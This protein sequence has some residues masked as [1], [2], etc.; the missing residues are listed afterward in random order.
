M[1]IITKKKNY[2][3]CAFFLTSFFSF[4]Q[5]STVD[6]WESIILNTDTFTYQTNDAAITDNNWITSSYDD[7]SW[8]Q[9]I[10]GIGYG[11]D[12]DNTVISGITSVFLRKEFTIKDTSQIASMILNIDYDD[13]FVAYLNG[14]EIAR[15]EGLNDL[16]PSYNTLSSS[17]H[18]AEIPDGGSPDNNTIST[19]ILNNYLHNGSN[20]LAVQVHNVSTTSSDFSSNVW[21]SVGLNTKEELYRSIPSWFTP[22]IS[23]FSSNLP[24]VV[25]ET[26]GATIIE[27]TKINAHMGIIYNDNGDTNYSDGEYNHYDGTIGIEIRGNSTADF[28]KKPYNIETR[29]SVGDNLNVKLLGMHKENDWVLRA[30]YIDH[31]FA[32]NSLADHLARETGFWAA[33]TRHVEVILDGEYQGI[34]V[35]ME[36]IKRDDHRVD[37]AE[38]DS[39]DIS[40][41]DVT[42]GYIWEVTGFGYNFGERRK[43]KYPKYD[44]IM[45][46]QLSYIRTTDDAFRAKMAMNSSIYSDPDT[47]Y[48]KHIWA[49]SFM[50]EIIVQ[51]T[52]RNGDAYGWSAYFHKD[53]DELINAGPVWDFDQSSGNSTYPDDGVLSGW[54]FQH[55]K[56]SS[57][58]AFWPLLYKD[59]FF[60]YSLCK[61][62]NDLRQQAFSNDNILAY[63]DSIATLLSEAQKREFSKWPV[64]GKN[65]YRET[66]GYQDRDTYKKEVDYLKDWLTQRLTWIDDQLSGYSIPDGYPEITVA[67]GIN[68]LSAYLDD[69]KSYIN[70][71]DIFSYTYSPDLEYDASSSNKDILSTDV[72]KSDSVRIK[73]KEV[74]SAN[75]TLSAKDTYG[76]TKSTLITYNVLEGSSGMNQAEENYQTT[77]IFPNPA[78]NNINISINRNCNNLEIKL[79]NIAGQYLATIYKGNNTSTVD[80][81]CC[82]L[83][84]GIYLVQITSDNAPIETQRL[85]ITK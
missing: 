82:Y 25:I 28:D 17:N 81:D 63:V 10:G 51:E 84:S 59:P 13:A 73:L 71:H 65:I 53:K 7:S 58:P 85:I 57:T 15:S 61:E 37:I 40:G 27:D 42:G 24:I 64:L 22:P 72:K 21:L 23:G 48:V 50:S 5:L 20:L 60:Y 45:P 76:N 49:E 54:M 69:E 36:K 83:S 67:T 4:A 38:L 32:R 62:W 80:Y 34:Y 30:S 39:S 55:E 35:L 47:G 79:Y 44:D 26:N 46:E 2:F 68:E 6:H 1:N 18:D 77:K 74:G 11:D 12:D 75:I 16:Y 8:L 78:Q 43:I 41:N 70:L 29:D 14:V 9:A 3:I 31:T 66:T 56:K 52:M 19:S 33:E